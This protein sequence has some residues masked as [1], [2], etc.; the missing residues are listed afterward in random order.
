MILH[1]L[2]GDCQDEGWPGAATAMKACK[3]SYF[4]VTTSAL[5]SA[6][7]LWP[8]YYTL[9]RVWGVSNILAI[10]KVPA[11][12]SN[13]S[14][15]TFCIFFLFQHIKQKHRNCALKRAEK[16]HIQVCALKGVSFLLTENK[17]FACDC[18]LSWKKK[19]KQTFQ[20]WWYIMILIKSRH[21]RHLNM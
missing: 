10:T 15:S 2:W 6:F 9:W 14:Y 17:S 16:C 18:I 13:E 4:L 12:L 11:P 7:I 5:L 20:Y 19:R 1:E 3:I 8:S 21:K